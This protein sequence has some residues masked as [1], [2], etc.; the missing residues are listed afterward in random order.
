[1][2]IRPEPDW[3][4]AWEP[5]AELS[6]GI[7]LEYTLRDGAPARDG[8]L[9]LSAALRGCS[10]FS[11]AP[12]L[13]GRWLDRLFGAAPDVPPIALLRFS[14]LL[15]SRGVSPAVVGRILDDLAAV[16]APRR[17]GEAARR[18]IEASRLAGR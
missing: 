6:H 15:S 14:D 18:M 17:A 1:L 11:T 8:A 10:V 16:P 7:R 5:D 2:V 9:I 3:L 13:D 12:A 4:S